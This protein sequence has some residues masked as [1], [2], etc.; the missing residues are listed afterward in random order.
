MV[1]DLEPRPGGLSQIVANFL[2]VRSV[3]SRILIR[4]LVAALV[5]YEAEVSQILRTQVKAP[6]VG[7]SLQGDAFVAFGLV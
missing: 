1:V 6:L 2:E 4:A 3:R 7:H 5:A